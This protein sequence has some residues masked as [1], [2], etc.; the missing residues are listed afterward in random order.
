[1]YA[2]PP[3]I[4]AAA[5]DL[6][7]RTIPTA[8]P[9]IVIV[10]AVAAMIFVPEIRDGWPWRVASFGLAFSIGFVMF[11]LGVLGGG[12]V[13]LFAALALW[14]RLGELI[15]PAFYMALVG[16]AL[17]VVFVALEFIRPRDGEPAQGLA[18]RYK[19]AVRAKIPYGVA[20]MA[21]FYLAAPFMGWR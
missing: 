12:D 15:Y 18:A 11:A 7:T 3:E 8:L 4:A 13:K 10:L 1:M 14:Y 20:I 17:A 9:A 2:P 6:Y 21:G 19:Q 16:A 5:T